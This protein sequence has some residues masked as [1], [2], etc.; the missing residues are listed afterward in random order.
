MSYNPDAAKAA[1]RAANP[2]SDRDQSE[3]R[4]QPKF[5]VQYRENGEFPDYPWEVVRSTDRSVWYRYSEAKNATWRAE[6]LERA[7]A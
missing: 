3:D 4:P 2:V 7:Y 6:Q 1:W 5:L